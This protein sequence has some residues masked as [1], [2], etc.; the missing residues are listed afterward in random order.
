M[1]RTIFILLFSIVVVPLVSVFFGESLT[2]Q[3]VD[4]L[5]TSALIALG[6]ALVCFV[7]SELT[8]NYSKTEKIWSIAKS[9]LTG[10]Y[11]YFG[12]WINRDKLS[13]FYGEA[14]KALFKWLNRRSQKISFSWED[15]QRK[16]LFDPIPAPPN[17][18]NLKPIGGRRIAYF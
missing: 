17:P 16:L 9:K 12:Y 15:F 5:K 13:H 4:I 11:N 6:I 3:Q 8:N 10:H 14:I 7:L 1:I 2:N 18:I